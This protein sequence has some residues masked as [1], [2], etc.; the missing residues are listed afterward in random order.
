MKQKIIAVLNQKGGVGKTT[1]TI[2]LAAY[3]AKQGKTV[4]VVDADPQSNATSGLG[5][6]KTTMNQTLCD[7]LLSHA[8]VGKVVHQTDF[9]N[10]FLLPTDA[11]LASVEIELA[12]SDGREQVL[13]SALK[14]ASTYEYILIDCPPAL[15]LLTINALTAAHYVLIPVQAEYYA[16]EGLSQLLQVMQTVRAGLNPNL[17]LLGV[18]VTMYDKRT[19]LA[20]QVYNEVGKHFGDKLFETVIPRN[21]RLAEAPSFGKP[22]SE[23]DKWSRGAR[24]YKNLAKEVVNRLA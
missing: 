11:R 7:V 4:L 17:E 5:F 2:N 14:S 3:L 9:K 19:S 18:V 23:H 24:A 10:L 20:E 21:V 15:G 22:I 1:T 12:T 16:L 13:A 6:D 8:D